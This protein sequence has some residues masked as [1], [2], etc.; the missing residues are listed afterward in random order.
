MCESMS[1]VTGINVEILGRR[2]SFT[3]EEAIAL[4]DVLQD[5]FGEPRGREYVAP[6]VY[7]PVT[8]RGDHFTWPVSPQTDYWCGSTSPEWAD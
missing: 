5:A 3:Y 6:P 1:K 8:P 2:L 4:K 7:G